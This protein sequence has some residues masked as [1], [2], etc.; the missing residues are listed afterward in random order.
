MPQLITLH[1]SQPFDLLRLPVPPNVFCLC[2]KSKSIC[3][4]YY[5]ESQ[6]HLYVYQRKDVGHYTFFPYSSASTAAIRSIKNHQAFEMAFTLFP[7][8]AAKLKNLIKVLLL[9]VHCLT[10]GKKRIQDTG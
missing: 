6:L 2:N 7:F 4:G 5:C 3:T 10:D 9:W 8:L 1:T